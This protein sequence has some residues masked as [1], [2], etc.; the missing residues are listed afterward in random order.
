M[1]SSMIRLARPTQWLKNGIL[2]A[3]LV[4]AGEMTNQPKLITAIFAT[5]LFCLLSSAIYVFNDLKDSDQ[6]KLHPLKR[7]RPI[8]SGKISKGTASLFMA[9]LIIVGMVNVSR[10]FA[11]K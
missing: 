7:E 11:E 3:P 2:L 8:A 6:D 10:Y 4:F 9:I 5:A 1:V